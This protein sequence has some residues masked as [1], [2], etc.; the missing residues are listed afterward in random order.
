LL[1]ASASNFTG[2][3][4]YSALANDN[5]YT[6]LMAQRN[7]LGAADTV[8]RYPERA[9]TL[10][11]GKGEV[12]A[13]RDAAGAMHVPYDEE[14]GV[15]QQAQ[16]F[17]RYQEWDFASTGHGMYP[18]HRHFPYFE[19]YSRQVVKQADLVLAM[20]WRGDAFT[21]D[22]KVRNFAYYE[23]RTVRDSTLSACTQAVVAAEVGQLEL[24][25]DYLT[26]AALFGLH[27][28]ERDTRLGVDVSSVAGI[29]IA[30]VAGFGG[31]R[32]HDGQLSFAPRLPSRIS[33]LD[34]SIIW[35]GHRLRIAV[36][37]RE[38]TYSLRE[39]GGD[40]Q[41]QLLHHGAPLTLT[42]SDTTMTLPIPPAPPSGP[43]PAQPSGRTLP[44][45]NVSIETDDCEQA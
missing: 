42:A 43:K 5:I 25:H 9:R 15:H 37:P 2:P 16:G 21:Y 32:D 7:L 26:S 10:G 33:Q 17:T 45:R 1:A 27:D 14:L 38:V 8:G 4:T 20:H 6:N 41:V 13:W 34:F 18:L 31:M 22:Q 40:A 11:V 23:S 36:R 28:P 30:L 12:D 35:H 39:A 44:P 3:D 19:L 24:A 29:W